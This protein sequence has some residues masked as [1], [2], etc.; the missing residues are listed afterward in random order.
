MIGI[1]LRRLLLVVAFVAPLLAVTST[2]AAAHPLGNFTT[3]RFSALEIS[4][5]A[6]TIHYVD[7][8]V[9]QTGLRAAPPLLTA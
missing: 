5:D 4:E 9:V 1:K 7:E 3:N 2:E 6:I 8:P